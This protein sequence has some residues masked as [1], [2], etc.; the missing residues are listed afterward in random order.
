[1]N[2]PERIEKIS[3]ASKRMWNNWKKND[4]E[5][6]RYMINSMKS[7]KFLYD[8]IIRMNSIEYKMA[9]TLDE[10][11]IRWKYESVFHFDKMSYIP[12]FYLPEFN[13]VI[14]CYGNYWHANPKFFQPT[15][16]LYERMTSSDKWSYDDSKKSE[17]EKNGYKFL[18]YWESDIH[19][20]LELI[21]EKIKNELY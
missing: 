10:L 12:D 15:Q 3:K 1:M 18:Y 4:V 14:E 2:S 11:N 17:F 21:K 19:N 6:Y 20:N 9:N 8:N 5:M 13:M 16:I 7:K